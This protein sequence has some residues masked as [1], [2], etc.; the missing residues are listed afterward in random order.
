MG[1]SHTPQI[2]IADGGIRNAE[3]Y[4]RHIVIGKT[5]LNEMSDE[6]LS[7]ILAHEL[8]HWDAGD[9]V[10]LHFLF[11]CSL[12]VVLL[13]NLGVFLQK[14]KHQGLAL[15]GWIFVWPAWVLMMLVVI[16][17]HRMRGRQQEYECDAHAKA[18]GYGKALYDA[19]EYLG[20]F[21][22]GTSGWKE[23]LHATHPPVELRLERL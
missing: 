4:P 8:H 10:G 18:A 6:Q 20:D 1:L 21:E 5:L 9:S 13:F 14:T 19:L 3:T 23:A 22:G 7:G 12:P 17:V 2:L 16:P 11:A 15:V